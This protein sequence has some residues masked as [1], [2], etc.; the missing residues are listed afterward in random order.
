MTQIPPKSSQREPN[1]LVNDWEIENSDE[2]MS[3]STAR[4]RELPLEG[5]I[6]SNSDFVNKNHLDF[7]NLSKSISPTSRSRATTVSGKL[8]EWFNNLPI[9]R[10]LFLIL[11]IAETITIG[12]LLGISSFLLTKNSQEHSIEQATSELISTESNYKIKI[13]QMAF[14]FRGQAEN[15]AII[16]LAQAYQEGKPLDPNLRNRVKQILNNEVKA[17]Q[18]EYATLVGKNLKII[19]NAARERTGETFN[20]NNLVALALQKKEQINSSEIL[21]RSELLK[22]LSSSAIPKG[23]DG[24]IRY[25]ITPIKDPNNGNILGALVAGDLVNNK[26]PIVQKTLQE[27]SGGYSA[28]YQRQLNGEF[29]LATSLYQQANTP[30]N[31]SQANIPLPNNSLLEQAVANPEKTVAQKIRIENK[32]YTVA[33][34]AL[35]SSQGQPVTLL[36]RGTAEDPFSNLLGTNLL[37]QLLGGSLALAGTFYLARQLTNS[38][39]KPLAHLQA[40][41]ESLAKGNLETRAEILHNDELGKL[42]K[43]FNNMASLLELNQEQLRIDIAKASLLQEIAL[44]I[45]KS[46]NAEELLETVIQQSRLALGVDRVIYYKFDENWSGKIVAESVAPGLP[47]ALGSEINDPCFAQNYVEKYKQG[48]VNAVNNI[49]EAGLTACHLKQLE[50]FKVKANLV[51]PI[52]GQNTLLGLL[53]AHE[54]SG[55]HQWEKA[56]IDLLS[57]VAAQ[58]SL[59]F[60]KTYFIEQQQL[61]EEKERKAREELQ[62]RALE[63]LIEVDPVSR[64]DLSIR[65]SVTP[66]EIGTIA[67]SYNATIESLRK[68][69]TQ[70][71]K[72]AQQVAQ[73][74]TSKESSFQELS[75]AAIKQTEEIST[76]LDRIQGI[77]RS[78]RSVANNAEA[79]ERAVKEASLTVAAGDEAIERTVE[80]FI[81]IRETVAETAKKVKRL[82]ESSQ[83]IS[84]VVNLIGSFAEQTNLLALNASIEAA[85]AGEEGRGFAVVADEVRALARQSATATAEIEAL[86]AQIQTETN[87]VV[88]AM[89]AGTEQVVTGTKLVDETRQSLERIAKA[90]NTIDRLVE[91][92]AQAAVSQAI[93]SQAVTETMTQVAE[94]SNKTTQ[95]AT[96]VSESFKELLAVARDLQETVSKFKVS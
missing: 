14:G 17:R 90:S 23:Q 5:I 60:E 27:F 56:E 16:N 88:T 45:S 86:V 58:L 49:Y 51:T 8:S 7:S 95:E 12:T 1:Q 22:E 20:P 28:I 41:A 71:Q 40:S 42:A 77:A 57:Q 61:A 84:K 89:E 70:V 38:I 37:L 19:A 53:I 48:R 46:L 21:S 55:P 74:T 62:R 76:A 30:E 68:I 11:L 93:D 96:E 80:G 66:D 63:L 34:K 43:N 24:L 79:A 81:A 15:A 33:I 52:V 35:K 39:T 26:L 6:N 10:K 13:N 67:D 72:S 31:L 2:Q 32:T 83:K 47:Q 44:A 50:P 75:A 87:E 18:I 4:E 9:G 92:I 36:V 64:G 94:I 85:H 91:E 78:I 69:V 73:T 3:L 59:A 82:G 25:T 54:C 29:L 65:A